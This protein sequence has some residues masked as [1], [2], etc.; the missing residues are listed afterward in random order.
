LR[1][2]LATI[3]ASGVAASRRNILSNSI[4][5]LS[6][7]RGSTVP[8]TQDLG[9]VAF[10]RQFSVSGTSLVRRVC[11]VERLS[12]PL[13]LLVVLAARRDL[14]QPGLCAVA[15]RKEASP[16]WTDRSDNVRERCAIR[17][18]EGQAHPK[19][20][21]ASPA[22]ARQ[23]TNSALRQATPP[24]EVVAQGQQEGLRRPLGGEPQLPAVVSS[25]ANYPL[26]TAL[27]HSAVT[28]VLSNH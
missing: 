12:S 16:Q 8:G 26:S 19:R 11:E 27:S 24:D 3:G 9:S 18:H 4:S 6:S 17:P 21:A 13:L 15:L 2:A 10:A 1:G 23:P 5:V 7:L 28:C 20:V 22:P 14:C 25:E